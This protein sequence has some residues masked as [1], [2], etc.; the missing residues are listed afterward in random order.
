MAAEASTQPVGG[1]RA[2]SI[3]T[4]L[5]VLSLAYWGGVAMLPAADVDARAWQLLFALC[6]VCTALVTVLARPALTPA[7]WLYLAAC[8]VLLAA[9]FFGANVGLD[10]LHGA[11]RAKADVA[12]AL[13][14]LEF[15]F[16]LCPGLASAA[17]GCAV[18]AFVARRA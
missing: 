7:V 2:A 10:A 12:G 14:G 8:F 9:G 5:S 15:W 17:L 13:G 18:G 1:R 11:A 3:A 4:A 16:V 6:S